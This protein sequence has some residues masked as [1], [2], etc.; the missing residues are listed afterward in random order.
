[1]R[2]VIN[3]DSN[4]SHKGGGKAETPAAA[5]N[6]TPEE[7]FSLT[8]ILDQIEEEHEFVERAASATL[9]SAAQ[10]ISYG[11][12]MQSSEA[13]VPALVKALRRAVDQLKEVAG[14][15]EMD[16]MDSG[17]CIAANH[18]SNSADTLEYLAQLLRE[19]TRR[20]ADSVP[21]ALKSSPASE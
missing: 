20:A 3:K 10:G 15:Y 19:Q 17:W 11:R 4:L 14:A 18:K 6:D 12:A 13:K 5:K 8:E 1:M 7:Q 21:D 16:S 2:I 9:W